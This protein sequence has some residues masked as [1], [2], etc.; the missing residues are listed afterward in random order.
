MS[1]CDEFSPLASDYAR[2]RPHYPPA[3]FD[4]LA[5]LAPSRQLA[6]DVATGNGQAAI[7]LAE[8]FVRVVA[9][10]ASS[11]QL[12]HA[13]ARNNVEYVCEHAEASALADQSVDLITVAQ[14]LHWFDMEGFFTEAKRVLKP[15]GLI[16][17]WCY[18]NIEADGELNQVLQHYYHEVVGHY[19]PPQRQWVES[20]YRQLQWPFIDYPAMPFTLT[21]EWT[22]A[23]LRGYLSTW[24]ASR[25]YQE[26]HHS[27]PLLVIEPALEQAWGN[28]SSRTLRW[29]LTLRVGRLPNPDSKP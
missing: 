6:W 5:A 27:D 28:A 16:A 4:W 26:T 29:P 10:D 21:A 19:W 1:F 20:G 18:Q 11:A 14:A 7:A 2:Y 9:T 17:V 15:N 3:L 23:G 25:R 22:L 8:R 24:S 12:A 13:T